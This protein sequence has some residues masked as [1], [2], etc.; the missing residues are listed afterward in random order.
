ML[1]SVEVSELRASLDTVL[2]RVAG[3]LS[4]GGTLDRLIAEG[5]VIPAS[6]PARDFRPI[7]LAGDGLTLSE[8]LDEV[9]GGHQPA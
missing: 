7:K 2:A 8:A 6:L 9:R 5:K 4:C 3:L 1:R